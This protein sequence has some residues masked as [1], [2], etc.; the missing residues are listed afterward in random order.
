M[1]QP[2]SWRQRKEIAALQ[3][4]FTGVFATGYGTPAITVERESQF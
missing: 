4:S 2:P 3:V 1:E